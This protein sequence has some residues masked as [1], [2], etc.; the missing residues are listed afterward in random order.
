MSSTFLSLHIGS[1]ALRAH[2]RALETIGHNVANV[3]T[4]GYT[5]QETVLASLSVPPLSSNVMQGIGVQAKEIR[6]FSSSF[7]A[8]QTRRE[9]QLLG[10]WEAMK[11]ALRDIQ[12]VF[13]EVNGEGLNDHLNR[14]WGAWHEL[15][16]TPES[17]ATRVNVQQQGSQLALS[18]STRYQRLSK[19]RQVLDTQVR[20]RVEEINDRAEQ[21]AELN[22]RIRRAQAMQLH[23]NDLLD[24]RDRLVDELAKFVSIN[25]SEAE[26]GMVLLDI[27][28][29]GLV[30]RSGYIALT[31]TPN[32]ANDNLLQVTWSDNGEEAR[33]N[34]GELYGFLEAR[35]VILPEKM[36]QL[37]EIAAALISNV[38]S[39]HASGFGRNGATGLDFFTGTG[40]ADIALS[41]AVAENADNI[42]SAA[43]ADSPGD[44]S[45]ALSI[46]RLQQR[47]LLDGGSSTIGDFYGAKVALLGL[48]VRQAEGMTDNQSLLL[49]HLEARRD[50]LAGVSLDEE[51]MRLISFQR[52]FQA[53]AR[54][55]TATDEMLDRLINGMGLVGR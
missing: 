35:D 33:I 7:L 38:N 21:I 8:R 43:S 18:L 27:G 19:L 47:P 31:V 10:Q 24:S 1:S 28:G 6:R 23:P 14:F 44:G 32:S 55:V 48:E 30:T 42:A 25:Y 53:A 54:V 3:N 16:I 46:A 39:L 50:E 26:D 2:Q 40:A 45:V 51:A 13:Q 36:A 29:H 34:G 49:R 20:E 15:S 52:A 22:E 41:S 12:A 5:R 17:A 4:P 11:D 37:D 9:N